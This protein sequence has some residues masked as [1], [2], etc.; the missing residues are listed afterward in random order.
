MIDQG[1]DGTQWH[2][3]L[4]GIDLTQ[5]VHD[6]RC[7]LSRRNLAAND[8][9]RALRALLRDG[10]ID[11]P[12]RLAFH[13]GLVQV[14]DGADDAGVVAVRIDD[15]ADGV[16]VGIHLTGSA[17]IDDDDGIAPSTLWSSGLG[18]GLVRRRRRGYG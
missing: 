2:C 6:A 10:V 7:E 16:A 8:K 11:L 12:V 5:C 17:L 15:V 1:L 3:G 9:L 14:G 4:P 13:A 18:G